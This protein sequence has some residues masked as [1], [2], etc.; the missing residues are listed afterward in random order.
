MLV[1][2]SCLI[3]CDLKDHS[4]L[5]SS[6]YGILQARTL[7]WVALPFS[8]G[9]SWPGDQTQAPCLA[10]R[11]FTVW[12]PR[13]ALQIVS[14]LPFTLFPESLL[15]KF[16]KECLFYIFFLKGKNL[17]LV[18]IT[19]I[20]TWLELPFWFPALVRIITIL[21]ATEWNSHSWCVFHNSFHQS[22]FLPF[23]LCS[24]HCSHSKL[25]HP[26]DI[27]PSFTHLYLFRLFPKP[28]SCFSSS[29]LSSFFTLSQS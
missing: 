6:V 26:M 2:Q 22:H 1:P 10:G 19:K 27:L 8:R 4:P 16:L 13:E 24:L 11:I 23:P 14:M 7:E 9:S 18:L 25:L 29:P 15:W 17:L 12:A 20:L 28:R 3:L 5:G 21:H